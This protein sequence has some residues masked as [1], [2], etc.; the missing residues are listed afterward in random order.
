MR[1]AAMRPEEESEYQ[2][3]PTCDL[4]GLLLKNRR[5]TGAVNE[6]WLNLYVGDA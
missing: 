4:L 5:P 3:P 2:T 1:D 6:V